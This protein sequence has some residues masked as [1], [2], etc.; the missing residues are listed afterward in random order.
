MDNAQD[1]TRMDDIPAVDGQSEQDL[2]DAVM[3]NSPI[4]D[5]LDI[6]LPNE[7]ETFDDP[8]ESDEVDPVESDEAVSE[9]DEEE[10]E[11]TQEEDDDGDAAEAATDV[12]VYTADDLDLDAKVSVKIDG[13][14]VEVSFGDLM[15][16]YTTEQSLSKKGRELGEARKELDAEREQKLGE[17]DQIAVASSNILVGAEQSYSK[18]YHEIEAQIAKARADGDTYEL[19]ELKDKRE[20]AQA[21]YWGARKQRESLMENVAAQKQQAES[22]KFQEQI[23]NFANVIPDMIPDFNE[24]VAKS[25]REF[26]VTEGINEGLLD[27]IVDPTIVKFIDDYRRLKQGVSKGTAKRKA[28]PAKKALPTKKAA[29]AKKKAADKEKMTKA[30]AFREDSSD[31]DKMDFLRNYASKSLNL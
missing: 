10:V 23:D 9:D 27:G 11:E 12:D 15:K 18:L 25:I 29:P 13:E 30:R 5:D 28:A 14:N 8:E 1:S 2:L 21:N 19:G 24:E 6:P 16:G 17:L 4:M 26:A 22:A 7:E 31:A 3:R 20:Q